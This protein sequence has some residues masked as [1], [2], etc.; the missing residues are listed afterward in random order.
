MYQ[1]FI[2]KDIEKW[3]FKG[4]IVILYGQ[5]QSGKTTL[6]KAILGKF[7][8]DG[9]YFNCEVASVK[10]ELSLAEPA[11][12]KSFFGDKKVV[13]LDEAQGIENIGKVLKAFID[14]YP[15]QQ[16]IATGSSSFDLANKINEPL[17]GRSIE[18]LLLPLSIGEIIAK[19]G[20]ASYKSYEEF[21]YRFGSYP[22]IYNHRNSQDDARRDLE[23]I[24][25]NYLYKDI[26]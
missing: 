25:T 6:A 21:V 4:K 8:D 20:L 14:E 17:T 12:L 11:K 16:I 9:A 5:R 13:V 15:D 1:R 24:Q 3:L 19:D 26:L 22:D 10:R 23:N 7:G 2:Q 18:F